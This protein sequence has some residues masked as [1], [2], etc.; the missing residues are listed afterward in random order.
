M[1][2]QS[3]KVKKRI[4]YGVLA[5]FY[6]QGI[7]IILQLVSVP[8]FLYVLNAHE[9]GKWLM[10]SSVSQLFM[11]ADIGVIAVIMNKITMSA[12]AGDWVAVNLYRA[13]GLWWFLCSS[14]FFLSIAVLAMFLLI[15][16]DLIEK[17][18]ALVVVVLIGY[19]LF[20]NIIGIFDGVFRSC[21]Q[22][23]KGVV[24]TQSIRFIET[25]LLLLFI[26][27]S[28]SILV[29]AVVM[30]SARVLSTIFLAI[31]LNKECQL[32]GWYPKMMNFQEIRENVKLGV[33]WI[34][35]RLG[36]MV[37]IQG[38]T[39]VVGLVANPVSVAV[40]NTY[41]T[42][43]RLPLQITNSVANPY[44]PEF[45]KLW[46][47][48]G[49][50][51]GEILIGLKNKITYLTIALY[52]VLMVFSPQIISIW[53][54]GQIAFEFNV[55]FLMCLSASV[56]ALSYPDKIFLSAIN[57]V[58]KVS[59]FALCIYFS[60]LSAVVLLDIS[61]LLFIACALLASEICVGFLNIR[62]SRII[63]W[64]RR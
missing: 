38:V 14:L 25:G 16:L 57:R 34:L 9:Y 46:S 6:S 55:F 7:G 19:I 20:G 56:I 33:S 61:S 62:A 3:T 49:A 54:Q 44:W 29:S 58:G 35:Y 15:G 21:D 8:L 40:Y 31:W 5:N 18:D 10:Y 42:L 13:K 2:V 27:L 51:V 45:S 63:L 36:D 64:N 39:L 37:T 60:F 48:N 59:I 17:Y 26:Y 30:L 52:L 22:Y 12:G 1:I 4:S 24:V 53:T 32:A 50:E 23:A 41:R 47:I 43:A 11:M 28:K